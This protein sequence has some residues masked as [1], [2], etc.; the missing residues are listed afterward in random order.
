MIVRRKPRQRRRILAYH[1]ESNDKREPDFR[2]SHYGSR[3]FAFVQDDILPSA[4]ILNGAR[5]LCAKNVKWDSGT[6]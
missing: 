1:S 4:V 6:E 3:F 2:L 5:M